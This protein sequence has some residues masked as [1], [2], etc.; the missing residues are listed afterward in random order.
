VELPQTIGVKPCG[1]KV[2]E[3]VFKTRDDYGY[4]PS[5][6]VYP[7]TWGRRIIITTTAML[8]GCHAE[9]AAHTYGRAFYSKGSTVNRFI[10]GFIS[11][12]ESVLGRY[13]LAH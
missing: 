10:F 4:S 13:R 8:N 11:E 1:L 2:R 7:I 3:A 5:L 6:Q 9:P 12:V